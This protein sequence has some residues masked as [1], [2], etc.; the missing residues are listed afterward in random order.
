MISYNNF[1]I[2]HFVPFLRTYPSKT[3]RHVHGDLGTTLQP[4]WINKT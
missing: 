3:M 1:N 2:D 4:V